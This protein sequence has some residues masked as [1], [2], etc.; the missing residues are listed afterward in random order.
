MEILFFDTF[1][2]F[3]SFLYAN[4]YN[5]LFLNIILFFFFLCI[6]GTDIR[7]IYLVGVLQRLLLFFL[8]LDA[9]NNVDAWPFNY[10]VEVLGLKFSGITGFY[11]LDTISICFI[12]LTELLFV[13]VSLVSWE[14]IKQSV[15]LYFSSLICLEIIML[16]LF[17]VNDLLLFYIFFEA[18]LIP[19]F[20]FVGKWGSTHRRIYAAFKL[21]AYTLFGAILMFIAILW[22]YVSVGTTDYVILSKYK[23]DFLSQLLLFVAFFSS[24]AIKIPMFPV[25]LWLPEAHVEAPTGISVLLAGVLLKAGGYGFLRF[26]LPFCR[27]LLIFVSS[28]MMVV[29]LLGI[30]YG[31]LIALRQTDLKKMI[32]YASISHMNLVTLGLFTVTNTGISGAVYLMLI[33]GITSSGLFICVGILYDRYHTRV[34]KYYAGL[35]TLMPQFAC[36][37]L[38][39]A[40]GNI[41]FPLTGGFIGELLILFASYN[42]NLVI[43]LIATSGMIFGAFYTLW[44]VNRILFGPINDHNILFFGD[45]N[46]REYVILSTLVKLMLIMG[47]IPEY[48]LPYITT[49]VITLM[50]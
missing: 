33:H 9:E 29:S 42:D 10:Q 14:S 46:F 1:Y 3:L 43:C 31:S 5:I 32:A 13:I 20:L 12:L 36:M 30:V 50:S 24:F 48:I 17:S 15:D 18:T 35:A 23:F 44:L 49:A 11:T 40:L 2:F 39:L 22:L 45:L 37:L 27:D 26:A 47:T 19:M 8:L 34:I 38:L 41:S 6:P 7:N 21:A 4:F 16:F 25:H 28:Y